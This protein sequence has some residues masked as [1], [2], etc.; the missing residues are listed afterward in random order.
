MN[1]RK[2]AAV[3]DQIG[4]CAPPD[5]GESGCYIAVSGWSRSVAYGWGGLRGLNNV[6]SGTSWF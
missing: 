1:M 5:P 4:R 2:I 6:P 3:G